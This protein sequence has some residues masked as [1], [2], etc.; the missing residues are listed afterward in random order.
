MKV[1][2]KIISPKLSPI[3][4]KEFTIVDERQNISTQDVVLKLKNISNDLYSEISNDGI[5]HPN[6]LCIVNNEIIMYNQRNT[7][8][9]KDGDNMIISFVMAGG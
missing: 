3:G 6:Y 4:M 7:A 5:I 9:L 2:L 1:F 8:S